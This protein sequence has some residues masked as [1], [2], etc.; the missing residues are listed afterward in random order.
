VFAT[1]DINSKDP[2]VHDAIPFGDIEGV[3]TFFQFSYTSLTNKAV[4]MVL[5]GEGEVLRLKFDVTH[6]VPT[7]LR[8]IIGG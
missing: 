1:N 2:N 7:F 8:L 6:S 5:Y 4:A 3:W